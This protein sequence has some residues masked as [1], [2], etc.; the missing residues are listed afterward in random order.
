MEPGA[1]YASLSSAASGLSSPYTLSY[2]SLTAQTLTAT[3]NGT[4]DGTNTQVCWQGSALPCTGPSGSF[5]WY[6]NLPSSS[7]QVIFNPVFF[8]GA[9]VV[10]TTVPANN[11]TTSYNNNADTDY[12]Y[13][14]AVANE[15]V[16]TN[17]FPTFSMN[18][19]LINDPIE[20]GVATNTTSNVYVVTT[21]E[22]TANVVYQTISGTPAAQQ[23]NIPSNV[24]AKRLTWIEQR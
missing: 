5:G 17:T 15:N 14:L 21:A 9:F 20:T 22:G 13:A 19:T 4:V 18:G 7:E 10:N 6:A 1:A 8:Q 24:K 12:T 3:G 11:L 16:F 2:S 23:V